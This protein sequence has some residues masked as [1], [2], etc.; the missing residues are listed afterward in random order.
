[1][2]KRLKQNYD[3]EVE[4]DKKVEDTHIIGD[5]YT[6]ADFALAGLFFSM[7]FNPANEHHEHLTA[8][9]NGFEPLSK[10]AHHLKAEF[11]DYLEKRPVR[12]LWFIDSLLMNKY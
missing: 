5:K 12:P 4:E 9:L 2:E 3:T 1:M 8:I 6:I 10:Y 11:H 7:F